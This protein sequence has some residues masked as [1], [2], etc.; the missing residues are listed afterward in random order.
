M[1]LAQPV[2]SSLEPQSQRQVAIMPQFDPD[3]LAAR[4]RQSQETF[5]ALVAA[6]PRYTYTEQFS[7]WAGFGHTV[8]VIVDSGRVVEH[9]F[10]SYNQDR[11]VEQDWVERGDTLNTHGR[12]F[13]MT[14]EKH[15][16][17]CLEV[18]SNLDPTRYA[19]YL[20]FFDNGVLAHC[21]YRELMCI[22][23]C[24]QGTML[25]SFSFIP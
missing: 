8:N 10:R 14:M 4:V 15:Y 23:D 20:S 5:T 3:A 25:G 21:S 17:R 12:P 19:V 16:E 9:G 2:P 6:Q 24:S 1:A 11:N 7:S 22:D 13:P 18:L